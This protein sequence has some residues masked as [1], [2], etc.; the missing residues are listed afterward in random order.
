M[1]SADYIFVYFSICLL[2]FA[3]V[4]AVFWFVGVVLPARRARRELKAERLRI[5]RQNARLIPNS[6]TAM[7]ADL[8]KPTYFGKVLEEERKRGRKR[9][10]GR[11][12]WLK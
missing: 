5:R 2:A 10:T 6:A 1:T 11:D 8:A 4:Y 12:V 7:W 9:D 3:I